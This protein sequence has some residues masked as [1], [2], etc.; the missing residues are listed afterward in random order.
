MT[1]TI[2][3]TVAAELIKLRSLPAVLTTMGGTVVAAAALSATIV[4]SDA[5]ADA[6]H[7]VAQSVT[8]VQVG[9]I[10]IGVLAVGT[11]FSGR[12]MRIALIATPARMTLLTGKSIAYLVAAACTSAPAVGAGV[13]TATLVRSLVGTPSV[14]HASIW[15]VLLGAWT[16]LVLIGLL[17]FALS[18]LMRSLIPP[19]VGMLSLVLIVSPMLASVT[20]NAQYLPDR[21]GSVL[22]Q[23]EADSTLSPEVGILVLIAW[24]AVISVGAV[25]RFRTR[26]A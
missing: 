15:P 20:S 3:N 13:L 9:L 26:D 10:V 7:V 19:L 24:I 25:T 18:F 5:S 16:Y 8:F 17:A 11:E 1:R 12:S 6:V 21:A 22:Y 2:M 23:A 14:A 4:A